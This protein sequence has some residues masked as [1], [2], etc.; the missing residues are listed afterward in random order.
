MEVINTFTLI[1]IAKLLSLVIVG[2]ILNSCSGE[3]D[4]YIERFEFLDE[5][6]SIN[7]KGIK[8]NSKLLYEAYIVHNYNH[9]ED[10]EIQI[11][12][13]NFVCDSIIPRLNF[14]HRKEIQFYR[15]SKNTNRKNFQ[16]GSNK[17]KI[18]RANSND[19]LYSYNFLKNRDSVIAIMQKF[20]YDFHSMPN[21]PPQLFKCN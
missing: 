9:K 1:R 18:T 17:N 4:V 15:K 8:E 21:D 11:L 2:L 19:K 14:Y 3:K 12:I 13:D 6:S 10:N 5:Y 20:I 16:K 7:H